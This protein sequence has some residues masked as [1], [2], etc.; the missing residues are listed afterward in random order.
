MLDGSQEIDVNSNVHEFDAEPNRSAESMHDLVDPFEFEPA[1]ETN[2]DRSLP[3]SP[4]PDEP[5]FERLRLVFWDMHQTY[6]A[7]GLLIGMMFMCGYFLVESYR[8][9]GLV[10]I[11]QVAPI[12]A[13]F[14]VDINSAEL[15]EIINLPGVGPKL[16]GAIIEFRRSTGDFETHESLCD[17]PG[18]G[19]KKLDAIRPFLLPIE[20]DSD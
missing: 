2:S 11:D 16:A 14:Q 1:D 5:L 12:G 3:E 7:R 9:N 4:R 13:T 19:E 20:I 17:V 8:L 6:V 15:G 18:I 10:D